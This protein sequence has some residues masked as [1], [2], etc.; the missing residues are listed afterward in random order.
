MILDPVNLMTLTPTGDAFTSHAL[1]IH[2]NW[3][4]SKH[5]QRGSLL[6]LWHRPTGGCPM[7]GEAQATVVSCQTSSPL[8]QGLVGPFCS[9]F[10]HAAMF[11]CSLMFCSHSHPG[12]RPQTH[13]QASYAL[14][15]SARHSLENSLYLLFFPPL[16]LVAT[17]ASHPE[18]NLKHSCLE[19][20]LV[21]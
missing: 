5:W 6:L 1:I 12:S 4:F 11:Y 18:M 3:L 16:T 13:G 7:L 9:M 14:S 21:R 19:L 15:R 10:L 8:A 17:L 2:S 20:R